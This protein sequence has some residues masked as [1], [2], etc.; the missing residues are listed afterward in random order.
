MRELG[1]MRIAYLFWIPA[2]LSGC[3][4]DVE[5]VSE[6]CAASS[7]D[8]TIES[9]SVIINGIEKITVGRIVNFPDDPENP[10]Q[11]FTLAE[12]EVIRLDDLTLQVLMSFEDDVSKNRKLEKDM[13]LFV[14]S[15]KASCLP[16]SKFQLSNMLSRSVLSSLNIISNSDIDEF[17][18]AGSELNG[19]MSIVIQDRF[20]GTEVGPA[21]PNASTNLLD[22]LAIGPNIPLGFS[23][24]FN[25]VAVDEERLHQF[26]IVV[27][28]ASGQSFSI[29]TPSITIEP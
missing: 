23:L 12:N 6:D 5:S 22:F 25:D 17:H 10:F 19:L 9:S 3:G 15:A 27:S 7:A 29:D 21:D 13:N 11:F 20:T 16:E 26:N 4:S 14:S 24:K 8:S 2:I 1:S 18:I 28:L